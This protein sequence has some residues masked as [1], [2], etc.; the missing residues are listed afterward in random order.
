MFLF[1]ITS[2]KI[3]RLLKLWGV[4]TLKK[5][6]KLISLKHIIIM[7][8][9]LIVIISINDLNLSFARDVVA[10]DLTGVESYVNLFLKVGSAITLVFSLGV[11][12][13]NIIKLGASSTNL[14]MR[15]QAIRGLILSGV[16]AAVLPLTMLFHSVLMGTM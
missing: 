7:W 16:S 5:G 9:A 3:K 15:Q 4:S 14:N 12:V 13:F 10:A 11:F 8:L 6:D 1:S 2:Y